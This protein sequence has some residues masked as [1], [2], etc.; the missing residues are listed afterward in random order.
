MLALEGKKK[1]LTPLAELKV[2]KYRK[3][4]LELLVEN[5]RDKDTICPK[6]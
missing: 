3:T 2:W 4:I 5:L 1:D 6:R